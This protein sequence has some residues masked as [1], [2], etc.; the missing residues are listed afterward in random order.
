MKEI[1]IEQKQLVYEFL[2]ENGVP[3]LYAALIAERQEN[4]MPYLF[5]VRSTLYGGFDWTSSTEGL[6][7]WC[8]LTDVL[9][10]NI[11]EYAQNKVDIVPEG[12][13]EVVEYN[14]GDVVKSS[15]GEDFIT[16]GDNFNLDK[17]IEALKDNEVFEYVYKEKPELTFWQ[18]IKFYAGRLFFKV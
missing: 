5:T 18:K 13:P 11:S 7:F 14:I 1:T 15:A 6:E 9:V 16:I 4:I 10:D 17:E 2:L 12:K 3:D 8:Y